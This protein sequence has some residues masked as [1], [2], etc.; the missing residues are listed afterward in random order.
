VL[1]R[2][3][4]RALQEDVEAL[5]RAAQTRNRRCVPVRLDIDWPGPHNA[6]AGCD[7]VDGIAERDG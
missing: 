3:Q 5:R 2:R 7:A 4:Q 6:L 1:D